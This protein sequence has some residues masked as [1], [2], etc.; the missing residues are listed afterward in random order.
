M[1]KEFAKESGFEIAEVI[2]EYGSTIFGKMRGFMKLLRRVEK[3]KAQG[4]LTVARN[5]MDYDSE[6]QIE[7]QSWFKRIGI[8]VSSNTIMR[9]NPSL[10]KRHMDFITYNVYTQR[11]AN[12]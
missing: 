11:R 8:E 7:L 2:S 6:I 5:K 10:G 12:L 9:D 3:G 4:I 1:I